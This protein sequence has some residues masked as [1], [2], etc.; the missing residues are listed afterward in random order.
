MQTIKL[1][2]KW[3]YVTPTKTIDYPAGEHE[4]SNE[5][6]ERAAAEGA[7]EKAN[8]DGAAKA[9]SARGPVPPKG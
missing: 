4:V 1:A 3:S 8:G 2:R 6:A 5:I 9:S 7:T